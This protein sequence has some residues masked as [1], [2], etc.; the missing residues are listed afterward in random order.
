MMKKNDDNPSAIVDS[1]PNPTL[2][3]QAEPRLVVTA[4][5][6]AR[7]LFHKSLAEIEGK[8]GGEV[9]DCIHAFSEKGCGN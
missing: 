4:N 1:R 8:R 5:K 6:E 7:S 9:F 2:L 3:M